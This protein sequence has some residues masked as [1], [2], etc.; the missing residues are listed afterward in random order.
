MKLAPEDQNEILDYLESIN[1]VHFKQGITTMILAHI[2][3]NVE[4]GMHT[5]LDKKF[6]ADC[7]YTQG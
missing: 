4:M 1:A 5:S 2:Q 6:Y 3:D 7:H